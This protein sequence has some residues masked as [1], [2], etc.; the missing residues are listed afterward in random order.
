[1]T[2]N[3]KDKELLKVGIERLGGQAQYDYLLNVIQRTREEERER[4]R[5]YIEEAI[6]RY[7]NANENIIDIHTR[8]DELFLLWSNIKKKPFTETCKE[9][10]IE[11][12][13]FDK[14]GYYVVKNQI[15]EEEE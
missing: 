14:R 9:F 6:R 10:G 13:F 4:I 3:I 8:L 12:K 15:K 1:M 7:Y 2:D 5:E 11:Y